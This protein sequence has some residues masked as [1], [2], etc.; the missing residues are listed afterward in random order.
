MLVFED[1]EQIDDRGIQMILKDVNT[2]ELSM[3]LKTASD[4][5]KNKIFKNMSQRAVKLLK[6]DMETKGP[7]KLSDV[8]AA[9]QNIVRIAKRLDQE[10]QII[11]AGRG[12]EELIV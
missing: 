3:A 6:E 4:S 12:G 8:E 11:I 1:L 5:I 10:G 9:Q 2:E 7:V